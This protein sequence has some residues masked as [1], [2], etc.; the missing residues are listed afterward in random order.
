[1]RRRHVWKVTSRLPDDVASLLADEGR[2]VDAPS[3]EVEARVWSRVAA[4]VGLPPPGGG[5]ESGDGGASDGDP[6]SGGDGAPPGGPPLGE[7]A[8]AT[9]GAKAATWLAGPLAKVAAEVYAQIEN[10]GARRLQTVMDKLLESLSYDAEDRQ[11]E[12]VVI[13]GAYVEREL[14]A[15]ARDT[16]LSKYVL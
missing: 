12:T 11:G 16:D 7:V 10:I 15:I 14:A 5:G 1:M 8:T 4:T 3:A 9:S 6:A 2:G 13:D